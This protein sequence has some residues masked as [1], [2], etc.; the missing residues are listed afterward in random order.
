MIS[1]S[2]NYLEDLKS[3]PLLPSLTRLIVAHN[4]IID[5]SGLERIAGCSLE[6]L[7]VHDNCL[8]EPFSVHVQSLRGLLSLKELIWSPNPCD[9]SERLPSV[10]VLLHSRTLPCL[11]SLDG[12]KVANLESAIHDTTTTTAIKT[13]GCHS[14]SH[15][16]PNS[17]SN[18]LTSGPH[19]SLT[20]PA[21][22]SKEV[23]L[24][25]FT[26][27]AKQHLKLLHERQR[28][29]NREIPEVGENN[30]PRKI[31]KLERLCW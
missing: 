23:S 1:G 29:N 7:D 11:E 14:I 30:K 6:Y 18:D 27:V 13:P 21:T 15:F 5:I 2:T 12:K 16:N 25:R 8:T 24:P 17:N 26:A 28:R 3:I 9:L 22:S 19:S 20:I 10:A 31:L 4:K